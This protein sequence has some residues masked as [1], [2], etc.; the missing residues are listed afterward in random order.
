MGRH[1]NFVEEEI[2]DKA[3][4][5][6]QERGFASTSPED[7]VKHL[8]LSRSSIYATFGDKRGLLVRA[9][10]HYHGLTVAALSKIV[11]ENKDPRTGIE[12][13]FEMSVQGCYHPGAPSGCFMVNSIIE[14]VPE[15]AGPLEFIQDS[16]KECRNALVYFLDMGVEKAPS[17][18]KFDTSVIADYLIN[19]ISGMVVSAKAGMSEKDCRSMV[20]ATLSFMP[21]I[22]I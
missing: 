21:E 2:L 18:A 8:G 19:A 3:I 20:K 17:Y 22:K 4:V 12:Q 16:Y 14:F 5:L 9:L 15:D 6:F 10:K 1:R 7:L 11:A 13:I